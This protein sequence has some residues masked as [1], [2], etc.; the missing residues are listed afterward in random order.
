LNGFQKRI[1]KAGLQRLVTRTP[2]LSV[3]FHLS[4]FTDVEVG[5]ARTK[6]LANK[7]SRFEVSITKP[8]GTYDANISEIG[9]HH[10]RKRFAASSARR[11]IE[12][13]SPLKRKSLDG[14]T[15]SISQQPNALTEGEQN[16]LNKGIGAIE[17]VTVPC[18]WRPVI[19]TSTRFILFFPFPVN[20]YCRTQSTVAGA[21][22]T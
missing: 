9:D 8:S 13:S 20:N 19:E 11:W 6:S 10:M 5:V 15:K 14:H 12:T 22:G 16:A 21:Q 1:P 18:K 7:H 17:A 2:C 3:F 4:Y